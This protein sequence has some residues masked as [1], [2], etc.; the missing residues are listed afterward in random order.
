MIDY[1]SLEEYHDPINYDLGASSMLAYAR[2]KTED[3]PVGFIEPY[4]HQYADWGR[5]PFE[6][7][8]A[9]PSMIGV[10]REDDV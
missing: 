7:D 5:T 3:L 4:E 6:F 8:H 9:A 10:C 1:N 2:T